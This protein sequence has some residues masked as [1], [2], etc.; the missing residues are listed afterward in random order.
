VKPVKH[1][2]A[3]PVDEIASFIRDLR[4][5]EGVGARCLEFVTLTAC[6]SGEARGALWSE[7][8]LND[9]AP[10]WVIPKE[11]MK[12]GTEHRVPL[13]RDAVNLLKAQP[14]YEQNDLIFPSPQSRNILSDM[15]LLEIMRRMKAKG[16]P[17]GMRSCFRTW[18]AER[19][20]YPRE[21]AEAALAHINGDRVEAAYLRTTH[22][23]KRTRMMQ[24]WATFL[25]KPRN[26]QEGDNVLGINTMMVAE[27]S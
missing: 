9:T 18:A 14:R 3:I 22:L 19:T 16:V 13:S 15:T 5:V 12:A 21:I 7:L 26:K 25:D 2:N 23:Q 17:H 11:R 1:H 8:D 6:R 4:K 20:N 10:V 24:E 27:L